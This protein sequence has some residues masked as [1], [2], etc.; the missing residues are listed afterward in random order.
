MLVRSYFD[1]RSCSPV[2]AVAATKADEPQVAVLFSNLRIDIVAEMRFGSAVLG[3]AKE[4]RVSNSS[5]SEEGCDGSFD[6]LFVR[7]TP[8]TVPK[9]EAEE[10]GRPAKRQKHKANAAAAVPAGTNETVAEGRD[11]NMCSKQEP[12]DEPEADYERAD[13]VDDAAVTA[14]IKEDIA[15]VPQFMQPRAKRKARRRDRSRVLSRSSSLSPSINHSPS[16]D[17]RSR[18]RSRSRSRRSRGSR[19]RS[20][21]R[22]RRSRGHCKK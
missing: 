7:E 11:D 22:R 2:S 1:Y 6:L 8:A 17:T 20:R 15:N 9:A 12:Q 3:I 14:P 10:T 16:C 5:A 19:S 21:S 4:E 13:E 18:K